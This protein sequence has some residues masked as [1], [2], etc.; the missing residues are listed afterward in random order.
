M[1]YAEKGCVAAN[2][3]FMTR[4]FG[5]GATNIHVPGALRNSYIQLPSLAKEDPAQMM[6]EARNL[7]REPMIGQAVR[8][9]D[10]YGLMIKYVWGRTRWKVHFDTSRAPYL[11]SFSFVMANFVLQ[12][13]CCPRR[14]VAGVRAHAGTAAHQPQH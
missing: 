6:D 4:F 1:V 11:A 8:P 2:F 5:G 13:L 3:S 7:L 9:G 12:Q 14:M 10:I